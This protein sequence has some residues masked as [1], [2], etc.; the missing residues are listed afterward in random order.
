MYLLLL[1]DQKTNSTNTVILLI[2]LD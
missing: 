1:S 2:A